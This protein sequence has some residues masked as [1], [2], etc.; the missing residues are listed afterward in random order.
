MDEHVGVGID[1]VGAVGL[2]VAHMAPS[3]EEITEPWRH[4]NRA[5]ESAEFDAGYIEENGV[6]RQEGDCVWSRDEREA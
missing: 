2:A 3:V 1:E 6:R 5:H 4:G